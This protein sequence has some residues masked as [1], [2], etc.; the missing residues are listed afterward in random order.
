[1]ARHFGRLT[2]LAIVGVA[3][4][5]QAFAQTPAP[6][7]SGLPA[8]ANVLRATLSQTALSERVVEYEIDARYNADKKSLDAT[9]NPDLSQPHGPTSRYISF[10]PLSERISTDIYVHARGTARQAFV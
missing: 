2:R 4:A 1:M 7:G 8:G 6:D 5:M 10:S 9:G 3:C